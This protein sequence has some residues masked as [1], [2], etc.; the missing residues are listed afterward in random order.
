MKPKVKKVCF[1]LLL[2][3][4]PSL[5][6]FAGGSAETSRRSD[7]QS[8]NTGEVDEMEVTIEKFKC[9]PAGDYHNTISSEIIANETL[10]PHLCF[11]YL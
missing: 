1:L 7:S 5:L 6:L 9:E 2:S 3:L 4:F 10:Y 11:S 8:P